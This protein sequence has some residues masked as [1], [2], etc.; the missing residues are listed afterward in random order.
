MCNFVIQDGHPYAM[1][2]SYI[3]YFLI[4]LLA[5]FNKIH[6][7]GRPE[8]D[9]VLAVLSKN[10]ND[11]AAYIQLDDIINGLFNRDADLAMEIAQK[12]L[13]IASTANNQIAVGHAL[14]NIGIISDLQGDYQKALNQYARALTIAKEQNYLELQGDI[15]NN[16]SITLAV[17]GQMEESI[18]NALN[19]LAIYEKMNDSAR[20]AKIYNNLASR[21]SEM[22]Y[23]DEALDKYQKAAAINEK[24]KDN[25]KLAYNYGNIGLLYYGTDQIEEAL[26]FF[27]KSIALQDTVKDKYDFSIALHNLG[28]AYQR[29]GQYDNALIYERKAYKLAKEV[30]DDL[31]VI[32]SLNGMASIYRKTGDEKKALEY[33]NQSKLIAE[34]IGAR[35][36]LINIYENIADIYAGLNDFQNAFIFN[37]KYNYLK[38][39]ILTT[40]KDKAV[41][42][43]TEYESEKKQAEIQLLTKDSEI[44]KLNIRRQKTIRNSLGIV[45]G[46]FLLIAVGLFHRYRYVRKTRNELSEKNKI[47]NKEKERSDELLLNILPAETAEELKNTGQSEARH[48]DSV[49]VMFTD[50]KGFTQMAEKLTPQE[51][52][53]EIDHCFKIFDEIIE[54]YNIEKIKT[55]GDA[56]MCAGGLPVPNKTHPEDVVRAALDIQKKMEDIKKER[57]KNGKPFFELRLGIHTGPV[58]AGIVGTKKFQYDIWGDTVNIAARMESSGEVGKVNISEFTFQSIKEKFKCQYRGKVEA[59]GKGEI[60]MYFVD[61]IKK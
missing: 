7:D 10:P 31:G 59:K 55:I 37:Q 48:F 26:S 56:Y 19:A 2:K 36:Y 53:S 4:L 51:L 33:F 3:L 49:T 47:I 8:A 17:L 54:K 22:G 14:L 42:K 21:Y 35:Y 40:E 18:D 60:D 46:L 57:I 50:F 61:S 38:D 11:T 12:E 16:Y 23:V 28:L 52:V 43:I 6:A 34:N 44:Q 20:M 45:G 32:T 41:Q 58:V 1:N 25:K 27:Q 30:N 9:S 13:I 24:L 5:P 29:L 39:S 15:Y